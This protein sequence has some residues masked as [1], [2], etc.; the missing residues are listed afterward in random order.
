MNSAIGNSGKQTQ[1]TA[2]VKNYA[3]D[4]TKRGIH[5]PPCSFY[6][7]SQMLISCRNKYLTIEQLI[8]LQTDEL[9]ECMLGSNN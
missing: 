8:N 2:L 7:R 6:N 5:A 1:D 3:N 4:M 9:F